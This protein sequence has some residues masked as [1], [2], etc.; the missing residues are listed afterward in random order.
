VYGSMQ[1]YKRTIHRCKSPI[2]P[3]MTAPRHASAKAIHPG[4][5]RCYSLG[6]GSYSFTAYFENEV[7]RK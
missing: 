6:V 3:P 7:L 2:A 5:R 4:I 1:R